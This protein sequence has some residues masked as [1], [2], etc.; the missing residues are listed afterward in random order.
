M[1]LDIIFVVLLLVILGLLMFL[2]SEHSASIKGGLDRIENTVCHL[3]EEDSALIKE[4]LDQLIQ[5]TT[6]DTLPS[7]INDFDRIRDEFRRYVDRES[8]ILQY[9][10]TDGPFIK[11]KSGYPNSN[12]S[13]LP[14]IWI[15][16]WIPDG[17]IISAVISVSGNTPFF[18]SHYQ[19]LKAHTSKIKDAFEFETIDLAR[20]AGGIHQLR[21]Q[22]RDVD[23]T[24]TANWETEFRWLRESLEK[25]Y[26]VLRVHDQDGWEAL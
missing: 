20:V 16:T 19:K 13:G 15:N 2:R 10:G 12:E 14:P 6:P 26:W 18:E 23:L 7:Q 25:L 24:Q 9:D 17:N 8:A 11:Y 1:I 4:Q 5:Q 22:K 3:V 21:V